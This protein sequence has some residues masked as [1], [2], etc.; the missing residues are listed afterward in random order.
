MILESFLTAPIGQLIKFDDDGNPIYKNENIDESFIEKLKQIND[1]IFAF[2]DDYL[3]LAKKYN[4]NLSGEF[5]GTNFSSLVYTDILNPQIKQDF[6][7]EN[8]YSLDSTINVFEY[9]NLVYM[10]NKTNEKK[11]K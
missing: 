2:F 3:V 1:G 11:Q 9:L 4:L 10:I 8:S 6:K 5:I 7:L